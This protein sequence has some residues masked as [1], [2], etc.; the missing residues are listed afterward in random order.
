MRRTTK[1]GAAAASLALLLA[2]C[3][4]GSDTGTSASEAPASSAPAAGSGTFTIWADEVRSVPLKAECDK[5]AEANGITCEVV[6]IDFGDIRAKVVQGNQTGDVPDLFVGA[7]DWLGELVTNGVVTP[8]DLGAKSADFSEVAVKA[9]AYDGKSYG[10]P[11]AVE[12]IALLTNPA[13]SPECPASLDDLISQ[14]E[15][16]LKDKKASLP[17]ALQIG[18]KGDA[19]HW[20]PL[21]SANGGYIFGENADGTTNV[22]DMGVG[23]PGSIAA[24][25]NLQLMADKK[26]IKASV[27]GDIA[28]ES[29]NSGDSAWFITGPW[30]VPDALKGVPDTMV[31]PVPNG[32]DTSSAFIGVQ[33]M[34]I[35]TKAKNALIAQTFLNDYVMTTEFMDAMYAADPRP[36]AWTESAD[37]VS[38]NPIVKGFIDYGKQGIPQPS[39]PEMGSVWES[40]GLAEF[41]VASGEDP[42]TTMTAAG[43]AI[44]KAIAD[45]NG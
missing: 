28:K 21:Y 15:A 42:T 26:L 9:V 1:V 19:Y 33:T 34:F 30:N 35:P 37:K 7:H 3:S 14:G 32:S 4:S 25:E 5:F 41:K 38:A 11:Y 43:D 27:T 29:Y 12:N 45:A 18:D 6:Q 24:A 17:L 10:V 20:Y 22:E 13:L 40:L 44:N 16:L 36:P 31:C 8:F 39:V 23:Q 2:A